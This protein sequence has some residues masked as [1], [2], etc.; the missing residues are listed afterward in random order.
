M[1]NRA[2]VCFSNVERFPVGFSGCSMW[3]HF[4]WQRHP[5]T[6]YVENKAGWVAI[7]SLFGKKKLMW[8]FF[9][10]KK[11]R[12]MLNQTFTC[13]V[14]E[15]STYGY[16]DAVTFVYVERLPAPFTHVYVDKFPVKNLPSLRWA[17]CYHGLAWRYVETFPVFQKANVEIFPVSG[18][19]FWTQYI[20]I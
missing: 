11:E 8:S 12:G 19:F 18:L 13:F 5:L 9:L 4:L 20:E 17:P 7:L 2:Q 3:S 15:S 6:R 10:L 14:E 16:C 1:R